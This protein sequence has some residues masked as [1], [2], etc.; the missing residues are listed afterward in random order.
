MKMLFFINPNAG[1]SGI[2]THLL[3]VLRM[4]CAAGWEVRT[5]I[6]S[7]P[8]E[9]TRILTEE[10]EQYDMV[11][12]SGGDGTLNETVAGL[13]KLAQPPVLGYIPAGTTNDMAAT[14]HLSMDPVEAARTILSGVAMPLD[15]GTLNGRGFAYVAGFGAFTDV[16]YLTSQ[17]TKK[18][19]GRL[20][21][22]L[23]GVKSLT[24]IRPIH[25]RVIADGVDEEDDFLIGLFCST[26]SVGGFRPAA[27]MENPAI[28]LNDGLSEVIFVR[29]IRSLAELNEAAS[30][31]LRMDFTN[32]KRFLSFQ[33]GHIR[34][35]FDRHISWTLDGEDGGSCRTA[36]LQ[37]HHHAIRI[38][39]PRS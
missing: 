39:V 32:K 30:Q 22:L 24:E 29:N 11:V 8:Q 19:L 4:F 6:T 2:R 28:S 37:N 3:E 15:A 10:G 23:Q 9:I 1:R 18:V 31:L 17:D 38:M 34:V 36:D 5:H 20:A 21:Y 25:A 12:A 26:R 16:T 33:S 14:L 27:T 13:L 7:G 35:E